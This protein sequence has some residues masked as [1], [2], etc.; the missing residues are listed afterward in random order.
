MIH[1]DEQQQVF[2]LCNDDISYLIQVEE[3][4]YLAHLYFGKR[5]K[6]YTGGFRYPRLD[7]SFSPNPPEAKDRTFSLDTLLME[8]PGHGFGDFREPA[9]VMELDN[10]SRI[11]DFRYTS[12]RIVSGKPALTGLPATYANTTQEAETL[13]ITLCDPVAVLQLELSYTVFKEHGAVARSANLTNSS[14]VPVQIKRL[15]SAA[16]DF[17]AEELELI[18]L[19][20]AWA[21]ERQLT[22][23]TITTGIKCLDSKR[24]ASSHQQNP[25]GVL[26]TPTT[27]EFQGEAYGFS[28][29]YSGNH[30][31][32]VQKDPYDQIRVLMG[33]GS[34]NFSWE[35][36]PGESFQTPE[37][38]LVYS[39][40]G[41]N[42]LSATYH[43]LYN[44]HLVRGH[45]KHRQRPTL[46]NNWEATYFD[47][48]EEKLLSLADEAQQLGIELFVLDDGWFGQREND[49]TSLGDWSENQGKLKKG[50]KSLA[51]T[52]H[53]KGLQFGIWLEPEMV[54]ADSDLFR[55]HPDWAFSVPGR[56]RSLS[57]DQ[58]VLDFSREEVRANVYQQIRTLLDQ[59]PIDYVKWDMNRNM[60]EVF[61]KGLPAHRQGETAHR[62][63][64]GLYELM[65]RLTSEY[66]QI[67]FESCSGG[68]GRFDPGLLFYMPQGWISD[69]TDAVARLTIQYATSLAYPVSS[70]AAHVSAVPN[71]QTG[72]TTSLA[73]RGNVAMSGVL[74]YEQ[75]LTQLSEEEKAGIRQQLA[76]YKK[77]RQLLQFGRFI[78]LR[79]PFEGN[80]TSWLF[81][82]EDQRE[83]LVFY[84]RVLSEAS[85]PLTHL[86]LKGLSSELH[87]RLNGQLMGGDE[88]MNIGFYIDPELHGDYAT[89]SYHLKAEPFSGNEKEQ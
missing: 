46:I 33:I 1:F 78:R 82:S 31:L 6:E 13:I 57:R 12:Y 65:E 21:R 85:A 71:H 39:G 70:M 49:K 17:P 36:A 28:L 75:D 19:H 42:D 4:G 84:F 74:G 68:G 87:Y 59:I 8:Y 72:R 73:M 54:S 51:D 18:H 37:A 29:V 61:S 11:T 16:I 47:F 25:F 20:G 66:P 62:Y 89:A 5:V 63:I 7:R 34:F 56:G 27:T 64:L 22:R 10:G 60:T 24:G 52:I 30:E 77:H 67:L 58:Y 14:S 50:L 23:E 86:K 48:D 88:L 69:N 26:V 81:V 3:D 38:I 40:E 2:H 41:L 45:Y 83:A 44:D 76:F 55:Q 15:A 43:Q 80:H 35:V 32:L 79:S 9:Y 53:G